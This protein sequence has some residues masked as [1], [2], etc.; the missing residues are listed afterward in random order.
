MGISIP[1]VILFTALGIRSIRRHVTL[2]NKKISGG[3]KS[4][5]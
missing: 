3:E 5:A 1:F 2:A 4:E